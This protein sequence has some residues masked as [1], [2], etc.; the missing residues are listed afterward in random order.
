MNWKMEIKTMPSLNSQ[1]T[2]S[3]AQHGNVLEL[4]ALEIMPLKSVIHTSK[5]I[6][7][8]MQGVLISAGMVM[9]S[10]SHDTK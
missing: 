10:Y 9:E 3:Q 7:V 6:V 5:E 4:K 8:L 1:Q 2:S